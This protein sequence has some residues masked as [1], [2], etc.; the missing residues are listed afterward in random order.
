[1]HHSAFV[2]ACV[3]LFAT[4]ARAQGTRLLRQPTVSSTQVAFVYAGDIWVAPR[5]GGDARRLTSFPGIE[6]NP[7]FS[8]DGK[9]VAFSAQYGGNVDL[10]VVDAGGGEPRRLTWHHAP[11][12]ARGWTPDG[13]RILVASAA[14]HAPSVGVQQL[15]TISATG[16][17]PSGCRS[18]DAA[19]GCTH[20]TAGAWSTRK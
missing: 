20:P 10:Y 13:Q 18:P 6:S 19:R 5:A 7:H 9:Q 12:S 15:W 17:S 3:A 14:L 11:D 16:E 2:A 8:P 4:S 1:M